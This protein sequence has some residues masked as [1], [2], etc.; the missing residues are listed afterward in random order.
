MKTKRQS[1]GFSRATRIAGPSFRRSVIFFTYD[2]R[3][4]PT[5]LRPP[6]STFWTQTVDFT[7]FH[8]KPS[9]VSF[10]ASC[11][12]SR[13]STNSGITIREANVISGATNSWQAWEAQFH[14][15]SVAHP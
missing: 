11:K 6:E 8:A 9:S 5:A 7:L 14:L 13:N 1:S 2:L 12:E 4:E 3:I 15:V 10:S